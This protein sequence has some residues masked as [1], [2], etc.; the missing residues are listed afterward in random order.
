[1]N[2]QVIVCRMCQGTNWMGCGGELNLK[3]SKVCEGWRKIRSV[4]RFVRKLDL[5]FEIGD[6]TKLHWA[7]NF[8][9][10]TGDFQ[11]RHARSSRLL[12]RLA[13]RISGLIHGVWGPR[14]TIFDLSGAWKKATFSKQRMMI[15]HKCAVRVWKFKT[16]DDIRIKYSGC[17]EDEDLLS[18]SSKWR[19]YLALFV[20]T[21]SSD[22]N[23]DLGFKAKDLG[24]KVKAKAK[25]LSFK[26]KAKDL[27]FKAKAKTKDLTQVLESRPRTWGGKD[28]GPRPRTHHR[29]EKF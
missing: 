21:F 6:L 16:I 5:A 23:K 19:I 17:N 7:L 20:F 25:D 28:Q 29:V 3:F 10:S 18:L 1:M 15:R 14:T 22:V 26:A 4:T 11:R 8:L 12:F 2:L 9:R 27:S 13:T 24:F